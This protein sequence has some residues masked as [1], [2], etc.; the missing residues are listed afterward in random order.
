MEKEIKTLPLDINPDETSII[1]L[2]MNKRRKEK[3]S[4][5]T[6]F[7]GLIST[8]IVIVI[9]VTIGIYFLCCRSENDEKI[10]HI[11]S[12]TSIISNLS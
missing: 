7:I 12:N 9:I 3:S 6:L 10:R 8:L 5:N 11:D 4:G 2:Y 1:D